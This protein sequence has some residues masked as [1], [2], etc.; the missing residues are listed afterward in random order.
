M[1]MIYW[2]FEIQT[3]HLLCAHTSYFACVK[4]WQI[5]GM[6]V[7]NALVASQNGFRCKWPSIDA[8]STFTKLLIVCT[9]GKRDGIICFFFWRK[10]NL[11][12]TIFCTIQS[13]ISSFLWSYLGTNMG[14]YFD[15]VKIIVMLITEIC[16][17]FQNIDKTKCWHNI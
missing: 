14:A 15:K 10:S 11:F 9:A 6:Y 3:S 8:N 12:Q 1:W 16:N 7:P 13:K 17:R 4:K 5:W 2:W